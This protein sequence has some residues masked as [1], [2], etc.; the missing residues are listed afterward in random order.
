MENKSIFITGA[1]GSIGSELVRQLAPKNKLTL[2]DIDETRLFDLVEE[3]RLEGY[4]VTGR[5]VDVRN[6][7]DIRSLF[8][9]EHGPQVIF[10][11]A[12]RKHVTPM[13]QTP[14][15]AV[16][17][18]IQGTHNMLRLAK[19]FEVSAFVNISTDKVVNAT[20]V[21]GAT[22]KVAEIMVRN[23]GYTSVRFGN[24][25]GSR[26][27][28]IPIWQKQ[29]DDGKPLTVT[30]ARMERYMMTIEQ[31]C[32]LVINVAQME[33]VAGA[34]VCLDMGKQVKIL[35]LAKQILGKEDPNFEH[36]KGI[37]MIGIRPGEQLSEQ[38][39]SAEEEKIAKKVDK[40]FIIK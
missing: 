19:Q 17:V 2:I 14:M 34:V 32:S 31:A 36:Q 26:G 22:K 16:S 35:D 28:V 18:N 25:M 8:Y 40:Y 15:E 10:H 23:A 39:M 11:A 4:D 21:M 1:A 33:D 5:V 38:L 12:A 13:E 30:D 27:S 7:E 3:M 6:Y 24:V 9:A 29:I 20:C 37:R